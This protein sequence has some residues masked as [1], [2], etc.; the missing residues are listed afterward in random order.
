MIRF[1]HKKL[2]DLPLTKKII[3]IVLSVIFFIV[4]MSFI[5]VH[6]IMKVNNKLLYQSI[7]SSLSY[8]QKE[9]SDTFD[10]AETLS[11][12]IISDNII[13][14]QLSVLKDSL[15]SAD[16]KRAYDQLYTNMQ[17]YY[18][19]FKSNHV[20]YISLYNDSFATHT[21][22]LKA[23]QTPEEIRD[24]IISRGLE[25]A[26]APAWVTDYCEEYGLFLVREVRRISNLNLDSL[27]ILVV[28]LDLN[29]LISAST[30]FSTSY[31]NPYYLLYDNN[32]LIYRSSIFT[33]I[34]VEEIRDQLISPYKVITIDGNKYFTVKGSITDY[35]LDYICLVSYNT[36]Y[37]SLLMSNVV[38]IIIIMAVAILAVGL[39]NLFIQS[40]MKHFNTLILKMKAFRGQA[41]EI[42]D[43][44]YDYNSR[45]DEFG[46]LHRQF[47]SMALEIKDL[48]NEKYIN[49]LLMKDAQLKALETQINPHFLYNTLESVNW[50]A[51]AIGE[52]DISLMVESL[53]NLLRMTLSNKNKVF[54]LKQELELVTYYISIQKCRYEER[55]VYQL[56]CEDTLLD[57]SIPKLTIQPLVENAIHYALEEIT[58]ACHISIEI[59]SIEDELQ[60]YVRNNGSLF[61][62]E[63]LEKLEKKEIQPHGFG[64]GLLNINQRLMLTFGDSYGLTLFNEEDHAVAKITIPYRTIT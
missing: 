43:V 32:E 24:D 19:Q 9:I 38:Y 13:Q 22:Q 11:S 55:L 26:G 56:N 21:Y 35:D 47:D 45:Y 20:S 23:E 52:R 15:N 17:S 46:L 54:T 29:K 25:A 7:A 3:M 48:I 60:I 10:V 41:N 40:I 51:K 53:G 8:S 36:I 58:E 12:M 30:V 63:L 62:T 61:E 5:G 44:G 4:I 33:D 57:A 2:T 59:F 14:K 64:I 1:F 37:H 6:Y 18:Y 34:D 50:R 16:R 49:K 27:G 39:S 31:E 42:I 28:R